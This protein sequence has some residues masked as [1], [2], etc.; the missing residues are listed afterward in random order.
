MCCLDVLA[1]FEPALNTLEH[2]F[3]KGIHLPCM[4]LYTHHLNFYLPV[5]DIVSALHTSL[6][7]GPFP[8]QLAQLPNAIPESP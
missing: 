5:A 6:W 1:V 8:D 2:T 7:R 3:Y 4:V